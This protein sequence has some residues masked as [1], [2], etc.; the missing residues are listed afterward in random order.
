MHIW[1]TVTVWEKAA[2][3]SIFV[4]L[5]EQSVPV[6]VPYYLDEIE[7][8]QAVQLGNQQS[9]AVLTFSSLAFESS[10]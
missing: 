3:G 4:L 2:A 6:M 5:M 8:L 7:R 1:K 10:T 9:Q